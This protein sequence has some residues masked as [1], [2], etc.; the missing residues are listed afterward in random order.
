VKSHEP[1]FVW[2]PGSDWSAALTAVAGT[3][4]LAGDKQVIA[5]ELGVTGKRN[6]Q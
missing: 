4:A 5:I 3:A 2:E 6:P 1:L